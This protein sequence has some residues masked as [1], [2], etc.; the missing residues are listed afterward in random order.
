MLNAICMAIGIDYTIFRFQNV[1]GIGQNLKN[2]LHRN[3]IGFLV[4]YD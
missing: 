3:P 2:P 4:S 1:Y